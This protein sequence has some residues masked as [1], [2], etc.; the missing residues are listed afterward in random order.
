M[1]FVMLPMPNAEGLSKIDR[2][3]LGMSYAKELKQCAEQSLWSF[4][5]KKLIRKADESIARYKDAI[6][7]AENEMER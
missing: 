2:L 4:G 3:K 6:Y 7:E 1:G 5:K